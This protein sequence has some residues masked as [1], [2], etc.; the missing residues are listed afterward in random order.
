MPSRL[1]PLFILTVLLHACSSPE[2]EGATSASAPETT[3]AIPREFRGRW[4]ESP[5]ACLSSNS[6]RYE[7]AAGRIDSAAFGGEVEEVLLDGQSATVRL[8]LE[9]SETDFSF[10]LVDENTM[11]ARYGERETFTLYLCR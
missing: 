11:R 9:Q 7:I 8:A 6:R 4:A 3:H 1:L 10:T 5:A 2:E